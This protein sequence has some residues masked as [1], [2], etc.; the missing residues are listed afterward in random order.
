[1]GNETITTDN[2]YKTVVSIQR[3]VDA[4]LCTNDF[5]NQVD[6][7]KMVGSLFI[8]EKWRDD[9]GQTYYE[10]CT[11][12]EGC[13]PDIITVYDGEYLVLDGKMLSTYTPE[14]FAKRFKEK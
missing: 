8:V 3:E 9:S 13:T 1:M 4:V 10:L 6:I 2:G 5:Y 7:E 12:Q 14:E 11:N